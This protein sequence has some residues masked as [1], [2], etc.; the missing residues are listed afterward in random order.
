MRP[1]T[2]M[3]AIAITTIT[4]LSAVAS[5][6]TSS[7]P[8]S[9]AAVAQVLFDQARALTAKG[10]FAEA[11]PK[12]AESQRLDPGIGTEFHLAE[13][14]QHVGKTASAWAHYLEVADAAHV[15]KQSAR[16][17]VARARAAQLAPHLAH[18]TIARAPRGDASSVEIRRDGI[19]VGP[20]QYGVEA[21][22]DPGEHEITATASGKKPWSRNVRASAEAAVTVEVP[23]LEDAEIAVSPP[24]SP[25]VVPAAPSPT[26]VAADTQ[27]VG[28]GQR[29]AGI[30]VGALGIV[31]IGLGA[32]FGIASKGK[33]DDAES[34]CTGSICDAAGVSLRSDAI[35]AGNVA[36]A[37]FI[38]G[39][40]ML[41]GGGVLFFA[42]PR[43]HAEHA[44]HAGD[45]A[46]APMLAPGLGGL[47]LSG[48]F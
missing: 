42:A 9:N 2:A 33:H 37:A 15:V 4:F 5:A 48:R 25:V 14:E 31:G 17:R 34:H 39:G 11:C 16:E 23:P 6:Q 46:A 27:H 41:V 26:D 28:R 12:L 32:G 21:P 3:A 13:C 43:D 10:K 30:T 44:D 40:A 24:P 8:G 19:L 35:H 22:V 1:A 47:S 29:I 45:L 18:M 36:T 38:A 7:T 20:A